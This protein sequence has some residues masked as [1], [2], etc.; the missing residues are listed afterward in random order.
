MKKII[1]ILAAFLAGISAIAQEKKWAVVEVSACFLR[2]E[3]GYEEENG[4]QSLMGCVVELLDQKGY[5]AQVR[6]P[7]P[8]VAWV[9][10]LAIVRMTDD[11]VQAYIAAPKVICKVPY[12]HVFSEPDSGSTQVCDFILG[13]L[14]RVADG[15]RKGFIKVMLPS[16]KTGW[17][18]KCEV[19]DMYEWAS[20]A[21][22]TPDT[23][24]EM[25]RNFIG[26]PYMWGGTSVK[27]VDC[28]GLVSSIFFMNGVIMPRNASQMVNAGEEVLPGQE[29]RGDLV[30]FGR[31]ATADSPRK[32]THV[33]IYMGDGKIIHSSHL[34]RI[35]S[36][37]PGTPDYYGRE[38]I[39][40]RRFYGHVDD[41]TGARSVLHSPLYF[42][43]Q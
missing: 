6:T 9:N 21:T 37:I 17:V 16:G 20:N 27:A 36:L 3:P 40:A 4:T 23:V 18:R 30:F 42:K 11:E 2:E 13:N 22:L 14:V 15:H 26:V 33:A 10:D 34:V 19:Q 8:Y 32:I 43:Q 24:F 28:S 7:D 35:N 5:W 31:K 39:A 29:Q 41:G 25:A 1:L 12:T 38:I